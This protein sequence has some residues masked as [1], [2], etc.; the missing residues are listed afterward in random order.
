MQKKKYFNTAKPL[1]KIQLSKA[2]TSDRL[3]L[4]LGT[5]YR[6]NDTTDCENINNRKKKLFI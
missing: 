2:D 4:H 3:T 6:E 1:L 5:S